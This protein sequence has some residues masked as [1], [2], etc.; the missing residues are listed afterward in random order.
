LVELKLADE[1]IQ[2][3]KGGAH[4]DPVAMAENLK[5]ALL[6]NLDE[7]SKKSAEELM[8]DRYDKFR[9]MGVFEGAVS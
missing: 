8:Q 1:I 4:S 3:P 7:L 5:S 9:A 6:R 2:E